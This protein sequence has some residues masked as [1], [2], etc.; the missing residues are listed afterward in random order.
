MNGKYFFKKTWFIILL[1]VAINALPT[2]AQTAEIDIIQTVKD[3]DVVFTLKVSE[4]KKLAG[5]KIS[6]TYQE[7]LIKYLDNTKSTETAS[8]M[9][10]VNDKNPG[11]IIIV[12]ASATGISGENLPLLNLRF[13]LINANN[14]LPLVVSATQ[15][16][17]MDENLNEIGCS[18]K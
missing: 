5:I 9:H 16:Q 7:Q 14:E 17:L 15:C 4:A 1:F 13:A 18:I 12:M 6:I 3:V 2:H 8:F 11:K 10:V